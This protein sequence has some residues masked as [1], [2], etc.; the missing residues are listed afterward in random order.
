MIGGSPRRQPR[1][2]RRI[3]SATLHSRSRWRVDIWLLRNAQVSLASLGRL[4]RTPISSLMTMAVIAIALS[5]PTGLHV[6]LGNLEQVAGAWDGAASISL[7]LKQEVSEE[8]AG[9][10]VD[11]I[12]E[13]PGVGEVELVSREQALQEFR[14]LSGFSDVLDSLQAN[15]LPTVLLVQPTV[16]ASAPEPAARLLQN[17]RE[18]EGVELAQLDL[19]WVQRLQAITETARRGVQI[20]S[21]LLAL[22]VVLTIGNTIRLEIQNRQAEI[23]ISKLIGA[24]NTFI[25]RPFLYLGFWYGLF[26]ALGAWLLV[27]L[28][29]SLLDAPVD[30][31]AGL[32]QSGFELAGLDIGSWVILVG[33]GTL[34][35]LAGSWIAVARHLNAI[36]PA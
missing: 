17:L 5:L 6:L 31:L 9:R 15:P 28:A 29:V 19:Q 24:T 36:E 20:L 30:R 14:Q 11:R 1:E 23:E 35:G 10:L 3:G 25:R 7:F 33:G 22:A 2:K 27:S 12:Q 34:L 16:E 32:Y 4:S 21:A 26:G 8:Q 18:I 13:S